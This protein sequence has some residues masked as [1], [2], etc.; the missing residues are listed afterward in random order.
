MVDAFKS[1][2]VLVLIIIGFI[3]YPALRIADRS[4]DISRQA[5]AAAVTEFVDTTRG[6]GY[7]AV[8]D[9]ET[10]LGKLNGTGVVFDI[11]LEHYRK[12]IQ[13]VYTD[14]NNT[15]TFQNRFT[16]DY[17]GTFTKDI[18]DKL[19][20]YT[21]V[22]DE[23]RRYKMHAGDLMQV[24]VESLGSTLGGRLQ[25]MLYG[26]MADIPLMASYGGMVRSEAP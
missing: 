12:T 7:I 14:P 16:V 24:R 18:L 20:P 15:S 1:I 19:Y 25:G 11:Q 13:P 8:S 6:K 3:A 10:L 23:H 22:A 4:D 17:I 2:V 21:V 9:Y 5:A 26:K